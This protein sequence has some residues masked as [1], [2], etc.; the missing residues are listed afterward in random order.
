M[1]VG[2]VIGRG[3]RKKGRDELRKKRWTDLNNDP[4]ETKEEPFKAGVVWNV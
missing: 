3:R 1:M 4:R 2:E